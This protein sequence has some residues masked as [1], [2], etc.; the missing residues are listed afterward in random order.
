MQFL[1]LHWHSIS[2]IVKVLKDI[3]PEPLLL[4]LVLIRK[5]YSFNLTCNIFLLP[6]SFQDLWFDKI[7]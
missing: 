2:Q 4:S 5:A 6:I 1:M 7:K 3:L